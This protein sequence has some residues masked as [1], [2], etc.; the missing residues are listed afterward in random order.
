MKVFPQDKLNHFFYGS[1]VA[2]VVA[3]ACMRLGGATAAVMALVAT[4]VVGV[5]KEYYDSKHGG[6]VDR[7]DALWTACG[8]IPV[9]VPMVAGYVFR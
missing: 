2:M 6:T 4:V 1:V 5:L 3:V 7:K 8:A 9:I